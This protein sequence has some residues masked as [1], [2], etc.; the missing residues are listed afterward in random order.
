MDE[1]ARVNMYIAQDGTPYV[2]FQSSD[3]F[4]TATPLT[5]AVMANAAAQMCAAIIEAIIQHNPADREQIMQHIDCATIA[6]PV[7]N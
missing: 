4:K 6:P 5:Q 1:L 2:Q 7:Q 3:N